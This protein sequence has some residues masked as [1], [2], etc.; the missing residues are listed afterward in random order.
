MNDI[1]IDLTKATKFDTDYG[2]GSGYQFSFVVPA[3]WEE[4]HD[5]L[6]FFNAVPVEQAYGKWNLLCIW[7][8]TTKE[9]KAVESGC[10]PE[11]VTTPSKTGGVVNP[12]DTVVMKV[13]ITADVNRLVYHRIYD[14]D[15]GGYYLLAELQKVEP[16]PTI[17]LPVLIIAA[18][19]VGGVLYLM[20]AP[21]IR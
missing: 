5:L 11:D 16:T 9:G 13:A 14:E 7:D 15:M 19:I 21:E 3:D 20:I 18:V 10:L 2:S 8:E 12:G 4:T 1:V 17:S 6:E